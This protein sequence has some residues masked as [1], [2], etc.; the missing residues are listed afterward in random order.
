M[1]WLITPPSVLFARRCGTCAVTRGGTSRSRTRSRSKTASPRRRGT[2]RRSTRSRSR[3]GIDDDEIV[4]D[5][6]T[7]E[8]DEADVPEGYAMRGLMAGAKSPAHSVPRSP[9]VFASDYDSEDAVKRR[10]RRR[11]L[12][13]QSVRVCGCVCA[14][15]CV[16]EQACV[17]ACYVHTHVCMCVR[18]HA[19]MHVY[20]HACVRVQVCFHMFVIAAVNQY[21]GRRA[22]SLPPA[23][24]AT[25]V[26]GSAVL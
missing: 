11:A 20:V 1:P 24:P 17:Y 16:C 8:R 12:L 14:C 4:E 5:L 18:M 3:H 10:Q 15:V 6:A 23:I 22:T 2:S 26:V 9:S 25:R 19:C 7:P 21:A 13:A